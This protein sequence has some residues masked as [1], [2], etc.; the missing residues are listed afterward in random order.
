MTN[1]AQQYEYDYVSV[2]DFGDLAEYMNEL[3]KQGW[4]P[5]GSPVVEPFYANREEVYQLTN[6]DFRTRVN[7]LVRRKK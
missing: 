2:C 4:E 3:T 6:R 7:L 1:T 5:C